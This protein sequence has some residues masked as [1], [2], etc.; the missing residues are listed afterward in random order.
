MVKTSVGSGCL[1]LVQEQQ[2]VSLSCFA[3]MKMLRN[4]TLDVMG[5]QCPVSAHQPGFVF[6]FVDSGLGVDQTDVGR[7][8]YWNS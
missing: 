5:G 1:G 3:T 2:S 7:V 4:S 6:H 8:L